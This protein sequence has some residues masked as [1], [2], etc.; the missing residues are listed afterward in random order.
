MILGVELLTACVSNDVVRAPRR[1][2]LASNSG[3][4]RVSRAEE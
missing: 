2:Y 4:H 1:P 3:K